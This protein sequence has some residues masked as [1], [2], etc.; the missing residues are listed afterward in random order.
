MSTLWHPVGPLQARVYWIRR[1]VVLG[2]ILVVIL[3][4]AEACSGGGSGSPGGGRPAASRHHTQTPQ[5]S[6]T[7]VPACDPSTLK[8]K[9]STDTETYT[10][11]Q[12]PKLIG[13]F[14]NPTSTSCRLEMSPSQEIWTVK[15]GTDKIWTTQGCA[16]SQI[17]K[18]VKLRAGATKMISTFWDGHR[19]D[20][21]CA[22]G[23]VA[24]PGEYT[25]SGTLDGVKGSVAVFHITS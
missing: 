12:A 15:S 8:L 25:L 17:A 6:R 16:S 7:P 11:G 18:Q 21:G 10:S 2:V 3:I 20:P 19:L 4:I 9:L 5:P 24:Q 22:E 23:A 1:A 14:S 13:V